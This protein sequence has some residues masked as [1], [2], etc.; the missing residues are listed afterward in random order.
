MIV[1]HSYRQAAR[2]ATPDLS[3]QIMVTPGPAIVV[4]FN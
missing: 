1:A 3:T 4:L 2:Q